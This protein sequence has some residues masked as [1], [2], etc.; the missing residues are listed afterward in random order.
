MLSATLS[1]PVT[2]SSDIS[3]KNLK[4]GILSQF[5]QAIGDQ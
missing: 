3:M 4:F 1:D 5:V 2:T